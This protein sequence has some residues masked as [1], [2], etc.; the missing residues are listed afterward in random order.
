MMP[1]NEFNERRDA[2]RAAAEDHR[3]M[4]ERHLTF[5]I[6]DIAPRLASRKPLLP[7]VLVACV[8]VVLVGL[9]YVD[10]PV[11]AIA[12]ENLK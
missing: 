8:V 9:A 1:F 5:Q 6:A 12:L 11:C 3:L 10:P 7:L 2:A 4:L